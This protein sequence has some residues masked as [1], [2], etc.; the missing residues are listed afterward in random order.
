M[1][2]IQVAARYRRGQEIACLTPCCNVLS[3]H[4]IPNNTINPRLRVNVRRRH[5]VLTQSRLPISYWTNCFYSTL[6]HSI[7]RIQLY[8]LR[9]VFT[10]LNTS[11]TR[12]IRTPFNRGETSRGSMHAAYIRLT[13]LPRRMLFCSS[14]LRS[15][16]VAAQYWGKSTRLINSRAYKR[17]PR[18]LSRGPVHQ[19][20][21]NN[22]RQVLAHAI[23][24]LEGIGRP[25]WA[26]LAQ[27]GR[28]G[29]P[30]SQCVFPGV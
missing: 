5:L 18:P 25:F 24:L 30:R 14:L 4:A 2:Y 1:N 7:L 8:F 9:N 15:S 29:T 22:D 3:T 28:D 17:Q 21:R 20:R 16:F 12:S 19:E 23:A 13:F 10:H 26:F 6:E 11:I 27:H